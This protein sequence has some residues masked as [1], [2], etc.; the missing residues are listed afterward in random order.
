[1]ERQTLE[2]ID[3]P[4]GQATY[5]D[6]VVSDEDGRRPHA[7]LFCLSWFQK[8]E[9]KSVPPP[10][11]YDVDLMDAER[12]EDPPD[13]PEDIALTPMASQS[14]SEAGPSRLPLVQFHPSSNCT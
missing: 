1:M 2:V 5:G 11:V 14:Q 6:Y 8:K 7:L 4:F 10:Q 12:E 13:V 3:V 9:K